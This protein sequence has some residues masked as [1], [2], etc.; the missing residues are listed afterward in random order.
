[1]N[2]DL[3]YMINHAM[4]QRNGRSGY[5]LKPLA[6]RSP[7]KELLAKRTKH[8]FQVTIISAQQLPRPKNALGHEIMSG[9]IVD[10]YVELSVY[11]PDWPKVAQA[12]TGNGVGGLGR[13][14]SV[15]AGGIG[16]IG[17]KRGDSSVVGTPA[18]AS[19][20]S[21]TT[22]VNANGQTLAPPP[23]P[24]PASASSSGGSAGYIPGRVIS[25]KTSIV[26][27]NGFNPVWEE[28]LSMPFECV[29]DMMDLVFVRFLVRRQDDKEGDEPL[30]V[31]C[32]SLGSLGRGYRHLP[33]HDSQLSQ[34][35][36]STL[37]VRIGVVDMA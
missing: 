6:L 23:A 24:S 27:D 2:V 35:L 30:A 28:E 36:F 4:F 8:V 12:G 11:V 15:K 29:G 10:P 5:V 19:A 9:G 20:S 21:S 16:L 18:S 14:A 7:N 25:C 17:R 26:K 1:M 31:Y 37:F 13:S 32:A 22:G 33:L 3:G 34:F